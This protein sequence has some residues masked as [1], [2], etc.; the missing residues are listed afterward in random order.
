M[1]HRQ[2]WRW[3]RRINP[4]DKCRSQPIDGMWNTAMKSASPGGNVHTQYKCS[5]KT[6]QASIRKGLLDG[7]EAITQ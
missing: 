3:R 4:L 2:P 5:G 7:V 1:H 6:T